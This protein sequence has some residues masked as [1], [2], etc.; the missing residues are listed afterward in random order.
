MK[1]E[2]ERSL[3]QQQIET[4]GKEKQELENKY[5]QSVTEL[6]EEKKSNK[7]KIEELQKVHAQELQA[8]SEKVK[9]LS[10]TIEDM[11]V[12]LKKAETRLSEESE[13]L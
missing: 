5:H 9:Q 12:S 6:S 13:E 11:E 8:E 7:H 1:A 4:L 2:S 3:L 10:S